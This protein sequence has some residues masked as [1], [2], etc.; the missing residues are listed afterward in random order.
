MAEDFFKRFDALM[1]QRYPVVAISEPVAAS[2]GAAAPAP[3]ASAVPR[4]V[5]LA[6]AAMLEALLV[7]WMGC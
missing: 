6:G 1:Q 5:R 4:W 3:A 2:A 7:W